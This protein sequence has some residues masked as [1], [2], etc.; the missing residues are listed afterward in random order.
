[1]N[2]S[3]ALSPQ[4]DRSPGSGCPTCSVE[5]VERRPGGGGV[6]GGVDRLQVALELVPVLA[7][8]QPERVADQVDDAGLHDRL[9]PHVADHVGQALQPVADH[10]ERVRHAAVACRSVSTLIQ[11][12]APSPPVPAH[13]PRMSLL[14]VQGDPDR[15]VDR[16]VGDLPVADLDHDRVDED[17]RVDLVQRPVRPTSFISSITLSVIREI[18]SLRHRRAVDLGEVR[19]DLPG[20]QPLRVQR[21][22]DLIDPVQPALPL[23]PRSPVRT[24]RPGPA[25]PRCRPARV[26][27][28]S[29]VLV[30]VPLRMLPGSRPAGSCLS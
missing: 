17:R 27:S 13:S 20:R 12:F 4:P 15:G 11:N 8:G 14:P 7:G 29:T 10:E 24:C 18:V 5:L 25:A 28:V 3:Q 1:M 16:P 22:H 30:R 9:R 19:A 21:Q 26:A 6:D 2:S 23:A